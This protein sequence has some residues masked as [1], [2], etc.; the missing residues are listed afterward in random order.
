MGE[1]STAEV[2]VPGREPSR[3]AAGRHGEA[4]ARGASVATPT[5][6]AAGRGTSSAPGTD[7]G[8]KLI[9]ALAEHA[10][11]DL[12]MVGLPGGVFRMGS[13]DALAYPE[14]GPVREVEVG[15]FAIA[16]TTVTVA[17]FAVFVAS[18]G[19]RT[20]AE[21]FGDSLVFAGLLAEAVRAQSRPCP[22]PRGGVRS[23]VRHGCTLAG[24]APRRDVRTV[25]GPSS[26]SPTIPSRM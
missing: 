22:G 2:A 24:P 19:F 17:E 13:E 15:P 20:E 3:S 10:P 6:S 5:G 21:V 12:A 11:A 9:A 16:A 25:M 26:H 23:R 14:E 18:T 7:D 4:S 1:E 8:A